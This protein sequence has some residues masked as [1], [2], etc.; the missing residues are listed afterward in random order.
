MVASRGSS[1][2]KMI[3][4]DHLRRGAKPKGV[5]LLP[6]LSCGNAQPH[7]Q[8]WIDGTPQALKVILPATRTC[9][10]LQSR[11]TRCR[12]IAGSI[13]LALERPQV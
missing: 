13:A 2:L 7:L 8:Y 11:A 6:S 1:S 3:V 12:S 4:H 5:R 9:Y 10:R